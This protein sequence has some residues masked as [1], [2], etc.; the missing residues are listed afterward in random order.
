MFYRIS[1]A[2]ICLS[3]A[4]IVGKEYYEVSNSWL[5]LNAWLMLAVIILVFGKER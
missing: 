4:L 5:I 2:V 3:C 1:F